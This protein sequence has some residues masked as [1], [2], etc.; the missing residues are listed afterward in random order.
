MNAT[1]EG[2]GAVTAFHQLVRNAPYFAP[3][4]NNL[5]VAWKRRGDWQQA[6]LAF[7]DALW[8]DPGLSPA[9]INLGEVRAGSG[10][11]SEAIDDYRQALQLDPDSARAHHL[12]G[13][14]L[15]AKGRRDEAD[16]CYPEGVKSLHPARG[17]ALREAYGLLHS[18]P[19]LRPSSG[20]R[21][22]TPSA[23]PRRTKPD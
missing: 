6:G 23:F 16:D 15:V 4:F 14:A 21:P 1:G 20:S 13:I 12:L 7:Q 10:D 17:D 8:N 3:G 5:G 22:A 19:R 18:D 11:L 9:H 2:P